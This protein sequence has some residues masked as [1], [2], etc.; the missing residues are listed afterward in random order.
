M[1]CADR[2]KDLNEF[3]SG[4]EDREPTSDEVLRLKELCTDAKDQFKRMH[5]KWETMAEEITDDT[6]YKKCEEDYEQ[7]K[8]VINRQ[9]KAAEAKLKEAPAPASG[10]PQPNTSGGSLKIDD[11][12][13]PKDLLMRSMS[14][15]EA[16]EWFESYRAFLA[17]NQKALDRQDIR[18]SRALLNKSIEAA[19]ASSLRAHPDIGAT[20]PIADRDG[21]L[22]KLRDIFLE[23]NPLWLRRH[24][25]FKCQQLKG[26]SVNEW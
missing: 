3:I 26:E 13:K 18:V 4:L 14:L 15:E 22:D 2:A 19:L 12:L 16:D 20:T 21:C 6:V 24:Y 7:S 25:Y 1:Y 10:A 5:T 8:E 9:V 23:K 11:M 17:H